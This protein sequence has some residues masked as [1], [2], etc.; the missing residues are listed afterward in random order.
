MPYTPTD[1]E[2]FVRQRAPE[3]AKEIR[4]AA[5]RSGN[6][7]DLVAAVER[8]L[9]RFARNFDVSLSLERERTLINGRADAVYNRFVIEYEPPNS[10]RK[11]RNARTN[12][13]AIEQ[14]KQY[15]GG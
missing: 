8:I 9:E 14:V 1:L 6:E 13:H 4:A 10:L 12:Q 3:V 11:E 7:A 2:A 5:E 15:L